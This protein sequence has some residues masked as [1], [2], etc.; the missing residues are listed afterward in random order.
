MGSEKRKILLMGF[1]L[2]IALAAIVVL[3]LLCWPS[4]SKMFIGE[5]SWTMP[6]GN[7]AHTAY[8]PF[9][10]RASLQ[11]KWNTRLE[12]PLT[13]P[14]VVTG[15]RVYVC[16]GNGLL[17][18]LDL[19]T[20]RPVWRFDAGSGIASM[21]AAFDGGLLLGT[22]DG[23]VLEVGPGGDL[24]WEVEVGGAVKSTPIPD[25][26][27]VYFGSSDNHVYCVS[28]RDGSRIWSFEAEGPVE[29]SPCLFEGQVFGVSYEGDLFALDARD[30]SLEWTYNSHEVPVVFPTADNGRV[31]LATEF[32]IHC[33]DAQSG[34]LLWS[35]STGPYII[36]NL[37]VRGNQLIAV[38]G[39]AGEESNTLSLDART[40]DLLWNARSGESAA[41][42][43]IA[44]TNEDV[45]LS[46]PDH[47]RAL[48][49]EAGTPSLEH[50]LRKVL[51]ETFTV[52]ERFMLA[53]TDARK[54]YCYQE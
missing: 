12:G 40:G 38:R 22:V 3:L 30:G 47:F 14:P 48:A 5:E 33:A 44:A 35:Y 39:G 46:G 42:T 1:F 29:L 9:A 25:G 32:M 31:F 10:P 17:Y 20:G 27:R 37:A 51:P 41:W 21:P 2:V 49:V 8:L 23:R 54:V 53:G 11:E 16:C 24:N 45:Y 26:G 52:T 15:D 34:K 7:P 43:W 18:S 19:E 6:G 36:S 28:A 4:S 13:G 50:E